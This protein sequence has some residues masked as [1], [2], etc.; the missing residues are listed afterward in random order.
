MSIINAVHIMKMIQA[1]FQMFSLS[2]SRHLEIFVIFWKVMQTRRCAQ[3]YDNILIQK[4][5][6]KNAQ[7]NSLWLY[8]SLSILLVNT[9]IVVETFVPPT[10]KRKKKR[11]GKKDVRI[12]DPSLFIGQWQN[13]T[14]H[15]HTQVYA[16]KAIQI[17]QDRG[18]HGNKFQN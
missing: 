15:R 7:L 2:R 10:P 5:L 4:L 11:K 18:Q 9:N 3:L 1:Q 16:Q 6:I 13:Q 12:L 17:L 14:R 8:Y